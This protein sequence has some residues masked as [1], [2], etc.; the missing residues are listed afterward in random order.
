M[1]GTGREPEIPRDEVPADSPDEGSHNECHGELHG[2]RIEAGDIDNVL[3]DRFR[4]RRPEE[5][6]PGEFTDRCQ[7]ES[8][9]RRKG[10]GGDN[11][12][13]DIGCVVK[14]VGVIKEKGE[15]DDDNCDE[16]DRDVDDTP[17]PSQ[18]SSF[19]QTRGGAN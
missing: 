11:G 7:H 13:H 19:K 10:S 17:P 15:P 4:D 8:F 9:P 18:S 1:G 6:G 14:P 3:P 16:F 2:L 12:G 5:Q